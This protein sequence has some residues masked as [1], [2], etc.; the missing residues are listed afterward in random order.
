MKKTRI[1]CFSIC[2][3]LLALASFANAQDIRF[4]AEVDKTRLTAQDVLILSFSISGGS[5]DVNMTPE[6][7]DLS[8]DFDILQGPSRSTQISIVN[9]KQSSTLSLSYALAPKHAGTLEIG[10]ATLA[11]KNHTY[12]TQPIAV[13]VLDAPAPG[14]AS[15]QAAPDGQTPTEDAAPQLYLHAEVDKPTAYIGEQLT[16]SFGLY[17]QLSIAGYEMKQQPNFTGFWVE[18]LRI[19]QPPKLEYRT[20]N[21][22]Q[23]GVALLK[24]FALFPTSSGELTIDPMLMVFAVRVNGRQRDPFDIFNDQFFDRTQEV[25]RK[26]P[27]LTVNIL[28]LPEENR[29]AAFNGD[30]GH[31]SMAVEAAPREVTQDEPVTVKVA[32]QGNGNIKTVKEPVMTLPESVKKYDTQI[33]ETPYPMQEPLQG[34]KVFETVIIPT[35]SGAIELSP[36]EFS[37]FDPARKSYQTLRSEPIAL[38]VRPKSAA[39]APIERKITT[40]E[41]IKLLGKDIRFIKTDVPRLKNQGGTWYRSGWMDAAYLLPFFLIGGAL[42]YKRHLD[43]L[44]SDIGYVRQRGANKRTM[45]RL[46]RASD[47]LKRGEAKEFYAAASSALRQYV[48][49]KLNLPPASL[50]DSEGLQR[51]DEMGVDAETAALLKRCLDQ[52]DF[53]RFAA[54]TGEEHEMDALLR[55]AEQ[56]IERIEASKIGRSGAK[57]QAIPVALLLFGAAALLLPATARASAADDLFRQGNAFYEAGKFA[58]AIA[59]YQQIVDSGLRN[60]YV[61]YNLGNALLKQNRIGEA[62]LQYERAKRLLPRDEDVAYNLEYARAS[63]MDNVTAASGRLAA[64]FERARAHFTPQ[65]VAG[66]FWLCY[67]LLTAL[68]IAFIF[69]PHEWKLRLIYFM[70]LP[71]FCVLGSAVLLLTQISLE[72]GNEAIVISAKADAKTGPGPEYSTI[73]EIHEG[74]NVRI[75]REKLDWVEIKLPNK[76]IGWVRPQDVAVIA[77]SR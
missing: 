3:R 22:Q 53:V 76:V 15:P 41:D 37:Y 42:L 6:L 27:P 7:P 70:L 29:P 67:L 38:T 23:Y 46:K 13:E 45:Q 12:T 66:F 1:L 68:I 73:F 8:K 40:K 77:P 36:V 58:E 47:L 31:F 10:A 17:T 62:I 24:R 52:C 35:E 57:N 60:G 33:T 72:D 63:T 9:N 4:Q 34:E 50:T 20:I 56:V 71:A 21:G 48:G 61:Y 14:Q 32:I 51:I 26:S 39:D 16:V 25:V 2:M 64:A 18:E 49:D 30:V 28:P 69:A 43:R 74:A 44:M 55:D 19:P 59:M 75:Q 54:V 5:I 65:E 11:Y